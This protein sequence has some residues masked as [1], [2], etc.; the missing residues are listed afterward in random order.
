MGT[1]T[2]RTVRQNY[3]IRRR[4]A[5]N[6]PCNRASPPP[7]SPGAELRPPRPARAL[8]SNGCRGCRERRL[9]AQRERQDEAPPAALDAQPAAGGPASEEVQDRPVNAL[10]HRHSNQPRA[11]HRIRGNYAMHPEPN[12]SD[13][14]RIFPGSVLPPR[15]GQY[16]PPVVRDLAQ[17]QRQPDDGAVRI[18]A[19][20]ADRRPHRLPPSR[21]SILVR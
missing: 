17:P 20:P 1:S 13:I 9:P 19:P 12:A 7:R 11:G 18:R 16:D 14:L 21:V 4:Q 2:K 10:P 3:H 6:C 15:R 8:G 5:I